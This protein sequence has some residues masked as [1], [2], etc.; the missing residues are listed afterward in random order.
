MRHGIG[1]GD[2]WPKGQVSSDRHSL[3]ENIWA[4]VLVAAVGKAKLYSQSSEEKLRV[5][6]WVI[7]SVVTVL[8]ALQVSAVLL[9][10]SSINPNADPLTKKP[11]SPW[12]QHTSGNS[13]NAM[14]VIMTIFLGASQIGEISQ[15]RRL[16][17]VAWNVNSDTLLVPRF[18]PMMSAIMQYAVALSVVWSGIAVILSFATCLDIVYSSM[19]VVFITSGDEMFYDM[20]EEVFDVECDFD[21]LDNHS[22]VHQRRVN[23]AMPINP[24]DQGSDSEDE[25]LAQSARSSR[26]G[27]RRGVSVPRLPSVE[28][29]WNE[30]L[31]L[32]VLLKALT[33]FPLVWAFGILGRA[34]YTGIMPLHRLQHTFSDLGLV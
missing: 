31:W 20:F 13:V 32:W 3:Y 9:I 12:L 14:K 27:H 21:V 29:D 2:T 28:K 7:G 30:P 6:V 10:V 11:A 8:F 34:M 1:E 33:V 5:P 4:M 24:R 18:V 15:C 19:S 17:L 22:G 25:E 16:A 26:S 23:A